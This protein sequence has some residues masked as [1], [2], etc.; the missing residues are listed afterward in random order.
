MR[1]VGILNSVTFTTDYLELFQWL[2]GANVT[3]KLIRISLF[4]CSAASSIIS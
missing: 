2:H 4:H 3:V 1:I